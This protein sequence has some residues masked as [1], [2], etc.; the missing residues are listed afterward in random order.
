MGRRPPKSMPEALHV[1][2]RPGQPFWN[3]F[4]PHSNQPI[5]SV[6]DL[7]EQLCLLNVCPGMPRNLFPS[8]SDQQQ[9]LD[10]S[11]GSITWGVWGLG[12]GGLGNCPILAGK[13]SN[14]R[15]KHRVHDQESRLAMEGGISASA[16]KTKVENDMT[17]M[18]AQPI[19][20][21]GA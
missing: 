21:C 14:L 7:C 2:F 9:W 8:L 12:L 3:E 1:H 11:S 5:L 20:R 15:E 19:G 10:T 17:A 16:A 4:L 13:G 18:A 6:R